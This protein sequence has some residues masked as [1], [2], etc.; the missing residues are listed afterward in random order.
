MGRLQKIKELSK[1]RFSR[2]PS[3]KVMEKNLVEL[4]KEAKKESS[5]EFYNFLN[6]DILPVER[7][8]KKFYETQ[9]EKRNNEKDVL[10]S[11]GLENVRQVS[12]GDELTNIEKGD[13]VEKAVGISIKTLSNPENI[14]HFS[15]ISKE[16]SGY[17]AMGISYCDS[18][19]FENPKQIFDLILELYI[20]SKRKG[21]TELK[22]IGVAGVNREK[23]SGMLDKLKFWK[24]D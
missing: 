4:R 15:D 3:K 16:K 10:I 22:E 5:Q 23:E 8:A 13:D 2:K 19:G 9:Q 12:S 20:S 21:R 14:M 17:M 18:I 6:Q 7:R 1:V 24:R 11:E